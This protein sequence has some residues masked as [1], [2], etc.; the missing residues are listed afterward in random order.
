MHYKDIYCAIFNTEVS[1]WDLYIIMNIFPS[2]CSKKKHFLEHA[3]Y[4]TLKLKQA[5]L[6]LIKGLRPH[7]QKNP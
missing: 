5:D 7:L 3:I 2:T 6:Q 4:S 1:C